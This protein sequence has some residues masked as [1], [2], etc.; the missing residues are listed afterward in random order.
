MR[1][2]PSQ[3]GYG[4]ASYGDELLLLVKDIDAP[5]LGGATDVKGLADAGYDAYC[6]AIIKLWM[7]LLRLPS[8]WT[9]ASNGRPTIDRTFNRLLSRGNRM[10]VQV[11]VLLAAIDAIGDPCFELGLG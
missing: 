11:L 4:Q 8:H 6:V 7:V 5:H 9:A 10:I 1:S 3:Y 2:C